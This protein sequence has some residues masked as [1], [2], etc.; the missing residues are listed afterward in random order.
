[1]TKKAQVEYMETIFVLLILVIIIFIGIIIIYSFYT[2]SLN[3]KREDI[4]DIDSVTLTSSIINMP[5]FTCGKNTNCID[6][7]KVMAFKK[8][9]SNPYYTEI[10]RNMDI[11]VDIIFPFPSNP[12]IECTQDAIFNDNDYPA[13][14]GR[15]EL[16]NSGLVSQN[17]EIIQSPVQIYFPSMNKRALG[18]LN[19]IVHKK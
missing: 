8:I 15:L 11:H 14:C 7:M 16:Y 1:M 17:K 10:F 18:V 4:Q 5:E 12:A 3:E 9:Q 19:I 2:R 6:T 13:N